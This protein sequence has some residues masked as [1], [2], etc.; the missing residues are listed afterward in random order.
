MEEF[1]NK[2]KKNRRE[3]LEIAGLSA[4]GFVFASATIKTVSGGKAIIGETQQTF[5]DWILRTGADK[6][7]NEINLFLTKQRKHLK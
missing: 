7:P 3:F 4:V 6:I 5:E 1:M 2:N